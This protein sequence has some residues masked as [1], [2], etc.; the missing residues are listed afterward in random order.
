MA[1][2]QN[3]RSPLVRPTKPTYVSSKPMTERERYSHILSFQQSVSNV[4]TA[5]IIT[6]ATSTGIALTTNKVSAN[7][8]V[9]SSNSGVSSSNSNTILLLGDVIGTNNGCIVVGIQ[10]IGITQ[11][12]PTD[13]QGLVY[14]S[15]DGQY[16]L[17]SLPTSF[18][19][20]LLL[21]GRVLSINEAT[22]S[23]PG[24]VQPD[25]VT[26]TI[27]GGVIS[28]VSGSGTVTTVSIVTANGI[29]G[30]VATATTTP[31]ITLTL[32]AITPTTIN[33]LTITTSTGTLTIAAAKT[34][35]I[36]NTLTLAGTDATTMTF[37]STSASIA[38]TDSF[39][40]FVGAQTF[41]SIINANNAVTVTSN[42]GTCSA[43]YRMNTFTNSSAATMAITLATAGAVDCQMMMVRV[44]D[45][46]AVAETIG[47]TNTENSNVLVPTTSNGSTTS[48]LTVGFQF[49]SQTSLWRCIASC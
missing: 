5:H 45:F 25:N 41:N 39:Q 32:G 42:A 19:L 36:S 28:A 3:N 7:T 1:G 26:I 9:T 13:G 22:S 12:A 46:S 38:R 35:T 27:S 40:S 37:P 20:P 21:T 10:T 16:D 49:N 2:I 44:Y 47:W 29:S 8:P 14:S 30:S 11:T 17:I 34:V 23:T 43:S 18:T 31:A 4:A 48:P 33:G 15:T 24:I 6:V